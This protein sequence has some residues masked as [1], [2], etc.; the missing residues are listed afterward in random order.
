MNIIEARESLCVPDCYSHALDADYM[1]AVPN[2]NDLGADHRRAGGQE[3][4]LSYDLS[5]IC[6]YSLANLSFLP[7]LLL[8][9]LVVP[10]QTPFS[11]STAFV[12]PP[13]THSP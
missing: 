4:N 13:P 6:A 5:A 7:C 8:F 9:F 12:P 10:G 1:V 11:L 2:L 3:L